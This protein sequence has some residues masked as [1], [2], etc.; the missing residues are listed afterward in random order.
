[1]LQ[2]TLVDELPLGLVELDAAGTVLY[3]NR[4]R[5]D[6]ARGHVPDMVGRN[7]FT[8]VGPVAQNAAFRELI[9]AFR[10]SHA[11][12]QTFDFSFG[13]DGR[14]V[15][16]RVLLA[17]IHEYTVSGDSDTIIVHISRAPGVS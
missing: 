15:P 12:A 13:A 7:F 4:D 14:D 6:Y 11:P 1:M 9:K 2:A 3:F 10:R 5:N 17:R 16:V 8:D